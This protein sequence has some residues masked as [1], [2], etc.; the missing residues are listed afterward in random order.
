MNGKTLREIMLSVLKENGESMNPKDLAKE[1]RE[2]GL[3]TQKDG[4][5]LKDRHVRAMVYN[6]PN[7]FIKIDKKIAINDGTI[8]VEKIK[9]QSSQLRAKAEKP[10]FKFNNIEIFSPNPLED[11]FHECKISKALV[12]YLIEHNYTIIHDNT[13]NKTAKGVD[14]EA[15]KNKVRELVEV[16]GY[17]SIYFVNGP[18]KGQKT[19]TDPRLQSTHWFSGCLSSTLKNYESKETKLAMAFPACSRYEELVIKNQKYFTD[20]DLDVKVYFIDEKGSVTI[21]NL[22]KNLIVTD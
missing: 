13:E 2:K 15:V 17:P 16:K 6:Y 19:K 7:S 12:R 8:V 1:I 14:I 3:Y 22:N 21:G 5:P 18:K 4:T 10:I 20:N 9:K 11:W